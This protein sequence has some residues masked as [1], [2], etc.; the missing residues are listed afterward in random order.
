M[1]GRA[2]AQAAQQTRRN[3]LHA[4]ADLA[5]VEGLD[6][7]T[8]GRLAD[9]LQMSKSGV[10]GPFGSKE[11]LQLETLELVFDDFRTRVWEPVR[12]AAPGLARLLAACE[13]WL[14]YSA[15]PGYPGGCLLT[16]VT[17][18]Y[19]GRPGAVH[20][21][22]VQGRDRWRS[23]LRADLQTAVDA[24]ELP[25]SL[26]IDVVLFGME[27][28]AAYVT[29]ARLLHADADAAQH[30]MRAVERLLGIAQ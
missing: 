10:I 7:V 28:L 4:A 29:P 13:A 12:D 1:A 23:T 6:S 16:Q 20:D 9:L 3:V 5:S 14:G 19:D 2:S 18:D 11:A 17:Y 30:G 22:L 26:D 27:S 15:D 8:V 21:R 24:A 25:A